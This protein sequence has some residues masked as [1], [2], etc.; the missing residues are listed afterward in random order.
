MM[1]YLGSSMGFDRYVLQELKN[2]SS[3]ESCHGEGHRCESGLEPNPRFKAVAV[4]RRC[5]PGMRMQTPGGKYGEPLSD[6]R[7]SVLPSDPANQA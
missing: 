3:R 4:N 6:R 1:I 7:G 5:K 2:K